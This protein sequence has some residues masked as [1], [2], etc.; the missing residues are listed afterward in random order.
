MPGPREVACPWCEG[1]GLVTR[2]GF[3]ADGDLGDCD[4]P[5]H[6]CGGTGVASLFGP[7]AVGLTTRTTRDSRRQRAAASAPAPEPE[8]VEPEAEWPATG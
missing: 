4:V 1:D 5:C 7:M 8:P 6:R 2:R 3:G